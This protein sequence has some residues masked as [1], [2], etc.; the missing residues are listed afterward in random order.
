MFRYGIVTV[1][2]SGQLKRDLMAVASTAPAG[3]L[4]VQETV[5]GAFN[6]PRQAFRRG[7]FDD[8]IAN[9][10]FPRK[11]RRTKLDAFTV[12]ISLRDARGSLLICAD[13]ELFCMIGESTR[14][15]DGGT[16][17]EVPLDLAKTWNEA[18]R[19]GFF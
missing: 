10:L 11:L 6:Y 16:R 19:P 18:Y 15:S 1:L 4:V 14:K 13:I 3:L 12:C 17:K 8:I 9:S 5:S 7:Q 2:A